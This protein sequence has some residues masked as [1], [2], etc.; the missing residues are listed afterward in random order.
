M[1]ERHETGSLESHETYPAQSDPLYFLRESAD[2]QTR[3]YRASDDNADVVVAFF[4]D[5]RIRV[6][7]SE[8][9][10]FAG[11]LTNEKGELLEIGTNDWSRVFVRVAPDGAMQLELHGGPYDMRVLACEPMQL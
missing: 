2:S 6:A 3:F 7:D 1:P 4:S 11:M 5:G 10:R 9:H 8:N